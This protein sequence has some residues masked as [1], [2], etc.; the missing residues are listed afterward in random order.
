M[1]KLIVLLLLYIPYNAMAQD[2][3]VSLI[4]DAVRKGVVLLRQDYQLLN[5]DDEPIDNK[6]G[7]EC[8]GRTYTCGVRVKNDYFLV[9]KDFVTPWINESVTKSDKRHFEV[10]YS[11][12]LTLGTVDFEQ[13]DC[14]IEDATEL[15]EKR[16]FVIDGSEYE[17]FS[18][19]EEVG[20]K[21]GY[22]VW[23][24]S[25]NAYGLEKKPSSLTIDIS[26]FNIT[27]KENVFVYDIGKQP[28]GNVIGGF[29]LVPKIEGVGKISFQVNGM[30]EKR[31]G[32]WKLTSLGKEESID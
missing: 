5:E 3:P 25:A 7:Q 20:K 24:K 11:G 13:I 10:S 19:D 32:V 30:F 2:L 6:F 28:T 21:K 15:V 4:S 18:I 31:G 1:K 26:S 9:T 22:A 27:T 17:G 16:L 14:D 8:Y 29:F 23:L 12:I